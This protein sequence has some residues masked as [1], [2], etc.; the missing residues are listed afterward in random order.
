MELSGAT[1]IIR[2]ESFVSVCFVFRVLGCRFSSE[3]TCTLIVG[4]SKPCYTITSSSHTAHMF[5][6]DAPNH[7]YE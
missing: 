4:G 7:R 2:G 5:A 3:L 6:Q 1:E